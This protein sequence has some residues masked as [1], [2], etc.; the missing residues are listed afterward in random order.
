MMKIYYLILAAALLSSLK[1]A[2]GNGKTVGN[3]EFDSADGPYLFYEMNGIN[4]YVGSVDNDGFQYKVQ[5]LDSN[6][7]VSVETPIEGLSF[8]VQI[9]SEH[10]IDTSHFNLPSKVFAISD[11]EGNF[12]FL[13]RILIAQN[14]IDENLNW[15][16]GDGHLVILGDTFDRGNNVTQVLWLLYKLEQ[17]AEAIGGKVHFILG[18]HETMIMTGDDRYVHPKYQ[19]VTQ[20]LK[21]SYEDLF[22]SSTVLGDWLRS[23]N[24]IVTLGRLLFVH[25][26]LSPA[27]MMNELRPEKANNAIRSALKKYGRQNLSSK[28]KLVFGSEGPLWYRDMVYRKIKNK[29]LINILYYFQ[30][31]H[32]IV[33]HTIV[34]EISTAFEGKVIAIDVHRRKNQPYQGLL[35]ENGV[36]Y[37]TNS[38]GEKQPL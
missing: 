8:D 14:I 6:A 15:T 24:A 28:E 32:V 22:N 18:N 7:T 9:K 2:T 31:D 19:R 36:F 13:Y 37:V 3:L 1:C 26:G 20:T 23:K 30:A 29:D 21:Q 16:F 38:L 4:S 11:V 12:D 33:G 17:E 10:N 35:I 25:A 34:E 5:R 27:L